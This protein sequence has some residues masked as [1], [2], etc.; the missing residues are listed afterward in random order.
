MKSSQIRLLKLIDDLN[1]SITPKEAME[2][3]RNLSNEEIELLVKK[4]RAIKKRQDEMEKIASELN[5]EKYGKL[6]KDYDEKMAE[7][8]KNH[9]DEMEKNQ[10]KAD[11]ELDKI[12]TEALNNL[13]S[14]KKQANEDTDALISA[15]EEIH[16]KLESALSK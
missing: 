5:P 15:G 7:L 9:L 2:Y 16:S 6:R 1:M 10:E 8:E 12:E 11:K 13:E 14:E 4:Y 3:M